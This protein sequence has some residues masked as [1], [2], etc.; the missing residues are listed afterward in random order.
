MSDFVENLL[1]E[2][3]ERRE[4]LRPSLLEYMSLQ[5][6]LRLDAHGV[7]DLETPITALQR[8]KPPG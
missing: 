3:R 1:H 7:P 4:Q 6:A 8:S 5:E 2:F